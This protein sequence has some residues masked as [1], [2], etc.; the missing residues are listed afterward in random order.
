MQL[1]LNLKL[2]KVFFVRRFLKIK[3]NSVC[4]KILTNL[5]YLFDILFLFLFFRVTM[6]EMMSTAIELLVLRFAQGPT[7]QL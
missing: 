3:K 5:E 2:N 6:R 1:L 7:P 4:Q